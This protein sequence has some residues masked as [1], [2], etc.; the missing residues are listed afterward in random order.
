[1][2]SVPAVAPQLDAR[3][4]ERCVATLHNE[5]GRIASHEDCQDA[6]QEALEE[7]LQQP[8]LSI[9]SLG[10]WVLVTARRKKKER[11]VFLRAI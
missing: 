8:E 11:S 6:V 3:A 10:G 4:W 1:M 9:K 7:A 5:L 2:A